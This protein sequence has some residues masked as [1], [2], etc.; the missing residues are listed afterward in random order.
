VTEGI[1][2]CQEAGPIYFIVSLQAG[3]FNP[4]DD[5]VQ[6]YNE[7]AQLLRWQFPAIKLFF[8]VLWSVK[9]AFLAL[10]FRL[11][12]TLPLLRRIWFGVVGFCVIAYIGCWLASILN[13]SPPSDYF[14][15]GKARH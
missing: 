5:P 15:P 13:C 1:I 2:Q 8:T 10:F 7:G 3:R 14:K 4:L 11:I 6:T 9:A 12:R